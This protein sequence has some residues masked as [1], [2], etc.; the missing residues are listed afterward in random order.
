M[1]FEYRRVTLG[2]EIRQLSSGP[3]FLD[4]YFKTEYY[5]AFWVILKYKWI[6]KTLQNTHYNAKMCIFDFP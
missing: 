4:F 6:P 1:A 3:I 5:D 2:F